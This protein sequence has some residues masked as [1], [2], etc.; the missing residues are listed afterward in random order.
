MLLAIAAL[1]VLSYKGL[2]AFVASLVASAIIIV[3]NWM[4]FWPS[5]TTEY[6]NAMKNFVGSYFLQFGFG[7]A[8]GEFM[9]VTGA[10]ESVAEKIFKLC[11]ARL[12][13]LAA[14][15]VTLLLALGGISAFVI[16]FAVYPIAAPLFRKANVSKDYLPGIVLAASVSLC[17]SFPGNPTLTNA[18]LTNYLPTN[19]YAAPIMGTIA[20]L[21]GLVLGGIYV[22]AATKRD[23]LKGRGYVVSGTDSE[24]VTEAKSLPPFWTSILPIL[25]VIA[26]MFALKNLMPALHTILTSLLFAMFL[27][28]VFNYKTLK[29]KIVKT[30]VNGFWASLPATFLTAGVMGF[31]GIVQ[32]APG[33]Q[34]FLNFANSLSTTFNPYVSGAVAVN[35]VAGI[36]GTA[37]GGL[38]I[39]ANTMLPTYL[40]FNINPAA[41]HRIMVIACCGLDTLPHCATFILMCSVC[42]VTPKASY[43]HVFALTVV[44]PMFMTILCILMAI[45]GIV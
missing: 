5:L 13:A 33:F 38:Q 43:K 17:L 16:V 30:F 36:T 9:K 6:A 19:A 27:V 18:L 41:F 37:L 45:L 23:K 21:V 32:V 8:Y 34:Y 24:K 29:G 14:I 15:L 11:G 28:V 40:S 20:G 1:I 4:P 26:G 39:F 44:I 12:A 7:A 25:A 35:V 42:G 2:N 10:A 22:T 31:A 3:T